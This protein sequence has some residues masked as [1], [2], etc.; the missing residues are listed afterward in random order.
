MYYQPAHTWQNF[1][2][3]P[4]KSPIGA[5]IGVIT[6]SENPDKLTGSWCVYASSASTENNETQSLEVPIHLSKFVS[7][8]IFKN[9]T[10]KLK[11]DMSDRLFQFLPNTRNV[12]M[13]L[14]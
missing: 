9:V 5:V 11:I 6:D 2:M 14:V 7:S 1:M 10:A 13:I 4:N 8:D 12:I 3:K